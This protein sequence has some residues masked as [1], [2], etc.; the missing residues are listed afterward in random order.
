MRVVAEDL[1]VAPSQLSRIERGQRGLGEGL[2]ERI[3][4]YYGVSADVVA[5]AEGRVPEDVLLILAEHP[6]EL[7]RLRAKYQGKSSGSQGRQSNTA[8]WPGE[9]DE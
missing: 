2:P 3:A 8:K 4:N 9:P 7:E 6:D 1:G 5:L